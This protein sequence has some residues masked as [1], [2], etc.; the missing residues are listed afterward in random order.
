MKVIL[1]IG[2]EEI[3]LPDETGKMSEPI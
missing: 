3:L 1:K 2:L